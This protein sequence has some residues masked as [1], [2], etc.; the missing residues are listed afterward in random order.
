MVTI[1]DPSA[2][3]GFRGTGL[4]LYTVRLCREIGKE[5]VLVMWC[6][7]S[8]RYVTHPL[9][10]QVLRVALAT[11]HNLSGK[12]ENDEQMIRAG[13]HKVRCSLS[14]LLAFVT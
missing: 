1:P 11:L 7:R 13:F 14:S 9:H 6:A 2:E 10:C 12:A 4:V 5:K 8:P 3:N